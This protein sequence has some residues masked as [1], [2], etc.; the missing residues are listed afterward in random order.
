MLGD[1][2]FEQGYHHMSFTNHW[3]GSCS[4]EAVAIRPRI[5]YFPARTT[6][7]KRRSVC[8]LSEARA[9]FQNSG[10]QSADDR[11]SKT[12][13]AAIDLAVLR[14]IKVPS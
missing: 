14:D 5:N 11:W 3:L 6:A 10:A 2:S 13:P 8:K 1:E 9:L 12:P 4:V 7:G